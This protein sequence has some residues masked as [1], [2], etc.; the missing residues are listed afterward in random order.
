MHH[1]GGTQ[2]EL[3]EIAI[4]VAENMGPEKGT[5]FLIKN[6]LIDAAIDFEA[7]QERFEAAFRLAADHARLGHAAIR[8]SGLRQMP[9]AAVWLPGLHRGG[10]HGAYRGRT[11]GMLASYGTLAEMY[12]S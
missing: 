2:K 4:K 7:N 1:W 9:V 6:G 10:R 5:Q 11:C 3:G 12:T 8:R